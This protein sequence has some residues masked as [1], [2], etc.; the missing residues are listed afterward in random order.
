MY[1]TIV[2]VALKYA[3]LRHYDYQPLKHMLACALLVLSWMVGCLCELCVSLRLF[4]LL[5]LV[6]LLLVA[7]GSICCCSVASVNA[8]AAGLKLSALMQKVCKEIKKE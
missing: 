3:I 2:R 7:C 6:H 1:C 8:Q 5:W 4:F